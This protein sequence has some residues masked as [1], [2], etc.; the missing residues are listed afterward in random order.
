GDR[1]A[2]LLAGMVFAG[3]MAINYD[4]YVGMN[5]PQMLAHAIMLAG[6]FVLLRRSN[7]TGA[8]VAAAV[9]MATALFVKHNIIALPVAAAL[10]LVIHN[11]RIAFA[12]AIAGLLTGAVGLAVCL[13]AFGTD[14]ISGLLAAR[15]YFPERAWRHAVEWLLPLEV[16]VLLAFLGIALG[17]SNR[18][19]LLFALYLLTSLLLAW[20]LAG[21]FGVNFNLMFDVVIAFALAAGQLVARLRMERRFRR[22]A[23]GAYAV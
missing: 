4:I 17:R 12:F 7:S 5:D 3:F 22:W 14:F 16:P 11:R 1:I 18:Y 8:A 9:L 23:L 20:A 2:A 19:T 6:L 13:A 21:G 15:R 10:W